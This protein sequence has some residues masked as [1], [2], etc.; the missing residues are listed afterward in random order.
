MNLQGCS[1]VVPTPGGNCVDTIQLTSELRYTTFIPTN[2]SQSAN[3]PTGMGD[4]PLPRSRHEFARVIKTPLSF[5]GP[6]HHSEPSS[7]HRRFSELHSHHQDSEFDPL[8]FPSDGIICEVSEGSV[9]S[10]F[11]SSEALDSHDDNCRGPSP[12]D[13]GSFWGPHHQETPLSSYS[14]FQYE[15]SR[16]HSALSQPW[17]HLS[18]D[19]SRMNVD[20]RT[21]Q[22]VFNFDQISPPSASSQLPLLLS[23]TPSHPQHLSQPD[24]KYDQ[25]GIHGT[26]SPGNKLGKTQMWNNMP[27]GPPPRPIGKQVTVSATMPRFRA[28]NS[29]PFRM[30]PRVT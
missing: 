26:V 14:P 30:I 12:F 4:Y 10:G 7:H 2:D 27:Q 20:S 18:F 29:T 21:R 28:E 5:Y 8:A 25:W 17:T 6:R 19:H 22:K 16:S 11:G 15:S 1:D 24:S 13:F 23:S 3:G 9:C